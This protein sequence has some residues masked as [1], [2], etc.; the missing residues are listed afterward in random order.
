MEAN[1]LAKATLAGEAMDEYDKVQYMPSIDLQEIQQVEGEENWMTPIVIYLKDG[2]LPEDKDKAKKLRIKAT[3][4][5]LIDEV[6]Y[7]KG[8]SQPYLRCLAPDKSNYVLREVHE[9]AW[10]NHSGV[11]ALVHKVVRPS[12]YW[13]TIQANAKAY[14][15]VYDQCQCFNNVP[16]QPSEYLTPLMALWPFAQWG[17]DILGP[18]P[19]ATRQRKFLVIGID[20]FTKWVEV[21]PLAKITQQNVKNFI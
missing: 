10:G 9:E 19:L 2:R 13:P 21:E 20:Y 18:F 5:V 8:F 14:V 11:R 4:Y 17:L 1:A 15:K 6:L 3:K 7:K 16:K 12:Y